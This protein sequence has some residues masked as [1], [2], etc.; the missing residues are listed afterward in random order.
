M[1]HIVDHPLEWQVA[2]AVQLLSARTCKT[3]AQ[4][5]DEA[6]RMCAL[7]SAW[8]PEFVIESTHGLGSNEPQIV[9]RFRS[10]ERSVKLLGG[11]DEEGNSYVVQSGEGNWREAVKAIQAHLHSASSIS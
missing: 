6:S 1:Q 8:K 4:A 3:P 10:N 9:F 2:V 7:E 11:V 5:I